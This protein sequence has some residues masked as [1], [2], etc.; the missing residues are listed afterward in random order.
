MKLCHLL[1]KET[2]KNHETHYHGMIEAK[3]E[4]FDNYKGRYG[5]FMKKLL[6]NDAFNMNDWKATWPAIEKDIWNF[7]GKPIVLTPDEDHPRVKDQ[8]DFKVGEIIDVGTDEVKRSAWE[9][10]QIIDKETQQLIKDRKIKFGSPTVLKYSE[11]ATEE[12]DTGLWQKKTTLHRFIPAHD[13]LVAEPA[14]G[15]EVDKIT[16]ICEGDGP[17]CSLKLMEVSASVNSDNVDQ[18][19]IVPFVKKALHKHFKASTLEAFYQNAKTGKTE[20]PTSC[21]S[22]KIKILADEHPTWD[23]DQTIA[24]AY[25]YCKQSE[26]AIEKMMIVDLAPDILRTKEKIRK[27]NDTKDQLLHDLTQLEKKLITLHS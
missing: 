17:A 2:L 3:P 26:G 6:I 21:V 23:H 20:L 10:A 9:V 7:V 11:A 22:K 15:K 5:F 24:V 14:Y 1:A 8:D 18:L 4:F 13:A 27:E 25:S 19:T 12:E 16:A